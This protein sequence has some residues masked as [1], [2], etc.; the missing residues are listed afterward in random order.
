MR[1][2]YG[3][4]M[5]LLVPAARIQRLGERFAAALSG[6]GVRR[7]DRVAVVTPEHGGTPEQAAAAQ[8]RTL[9]LV[10][11]ALRAGIIPVLVNPAVS[12]FSSM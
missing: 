10:L 3:V 6:R 8:A 11:G 1:A 2:A 12:A 9:G 5:T 7:G 4:T